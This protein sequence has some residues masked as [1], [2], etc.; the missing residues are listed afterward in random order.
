LGERVDNIGFGGYQL[1]QDPDQF[2][3]GVDAVL[4]ADF[5]AATKEDCIVD[6]GTGTGVIPLILYHKSKAQKI[7]GLEKQR[8]SYELALKNAK[9]NGLSEFL[10]FV[11]GDVLDIKKYFK[12]GEFSLV[13]TNP[14]YTEKGTGPISP[15]CAKETAKHETTA[16]VSEFIQA[17]QYLLGPKGS[18]CIVQRPSRL[19]DIMVA[20][21]Q[22]QLEPKRIKFVA[23][24]PG[25]APNIVLLQCIKNGGKE[26]IIEPTLFV[27]DHTGVYGTDLNRIYERAKK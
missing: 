4:L 13:V 9:M 6:L 2:C 17:A 18:F 21:R 24:V 10:R 26:L 8:K 12:S 5:A 20:C 22:H 14:P 15:Y 27:R 1:I 16:G 25:V 11:H 7:V 23:P 3:Y 19:V